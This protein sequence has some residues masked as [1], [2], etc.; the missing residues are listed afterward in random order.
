MRLPALIAC[1][2]ARVYTALT[3]GGQIEEILRGWLAV[4]FDRCRSANYMCS[5][6]HNGRSARRMQVTRT[7]EYGYHRDSSGNIVCSSCHDRRGVKHAP[8]TC[9]TASVENFLKLA[10]DALEFVERSGVVD[11]FVGYCAICCGT[12]TEHARLV[13][14]NPDGYREIECP[15]G[16]AIRAFDT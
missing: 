2:A 10:G 3:L 15:V 16:A 6:K 1:L 9:Q 13:I 4:V 5:R 14:M 11:G 8:E 12:P 7:P